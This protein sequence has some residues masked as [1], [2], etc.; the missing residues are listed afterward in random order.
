MVTYH[1]REDEQWPA[2][3]GNHTNEKAI[4]RVSQ[5]PEEIREYMW[6]NDPCWS[7]IPAGWVQI[8]LSCHAHLKEIAPE[9][10]I[11]QLKEKF[12]ALRFYTNIGYD[13]DGLASIVISHY[14]RVSAHTCD[15]C[16][17][18]G[19][20]IQIGDRMPYIASRCAEHNT[21]DKARG[22]VARTGG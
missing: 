20:I 5:L 4:E 16:G 1:N 3:R 18:R 13:P 7:Y 8:V 14:E 17:E 12:G 6:T 11:T 19:E 22:R 15:V 21:E 2:T 9:Y 10:R